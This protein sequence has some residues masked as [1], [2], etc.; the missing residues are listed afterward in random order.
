MTPTARTL[1]GLLLLTLFLA[2]CGHVGD[3][4]PPALHIPAPVS[5]LAAVERGDRIIVQFT[6]PE[7]TTD[8]MVIK[9]YGELD[10]LMKG[11]GTH[12]QELLRK[13]IRQRIR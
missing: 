11:R 13:A 7:L 3:P 12:V 10:H 6:V 1:F 5:D 8:G 9:E 2:G 4:M